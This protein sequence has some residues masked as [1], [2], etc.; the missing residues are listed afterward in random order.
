MGFLFF[1]FPDPSRQ[2]RAGAPR[3]V[4]EDSDEFVEDQDAAPRKR[5][6]S[7]GKSKSKKPPSVAESAAAVRFVSYGSGW[8]V[9]G[10]VFTDDSCCRLR[11]VPT[12]GC[13]GK[14]ASGTQKWTP[15]T[16][17]RVRKTA[18]VARKRCVAAFFFRFSCLKS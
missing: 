5:S 15:M 8:V 10:R 13:A 1:E 2:A 18:N 16:T 4:E 3:Y 6:K 17:S 14:N 11:H 7:K 9:A 12:W